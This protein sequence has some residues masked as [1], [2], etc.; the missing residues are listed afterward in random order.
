MFKVNNKKIWTISL[1]FFWY[2]NCYLWTHF[3]LFLSVS[4][5]DFEQVNVGRVIGSWVFS[6]RM[7]SQ[8]VKYWVFKTLLVTAFIIWGIQCKKLTFMNIVTDTSRKYPVPIVIRCMV[9]YIACRE[10][11]SPPLKNDP[12]IFNKNITLSLFLENFLK[13]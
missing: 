11:K 12:T 3:T 6:W 13:P 4:I 1:T 2:L 5:V 10:V 9:W 7:P 8:I